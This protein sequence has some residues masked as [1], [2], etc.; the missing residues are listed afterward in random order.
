MVKLVT[1]DGKLTWLID[2]SP[3]GIIMIACD[4]SE[5]QALKEDVELAIAK[6]VVDKKST[7]QQ[8]Q[9]SLEP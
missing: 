5:L 3:I 9:E 4:P 2:F 1:F 6:Q 7:M 8:V